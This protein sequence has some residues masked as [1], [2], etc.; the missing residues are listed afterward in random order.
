MRGQ[1]EGADIRLSRA[2][3]AERSGAMHRASSAGKLAELRI[4][5]GR[6]DEAAELL[7][8]HEEDF[9]AP[10]RSPA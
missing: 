3:V 6:Y 1:W 9:E 4:Q 2:V 10:P 8:D 7:K 5:Q